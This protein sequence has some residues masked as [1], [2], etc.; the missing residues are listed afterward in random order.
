MW[1]RWW[2]FPVGYYVEKLATAIWS[3]ISTGSEQPELVEG[4]NYD[5]MH[6]SFIHE[7]LVE[8]AMY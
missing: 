6:E 8:Y 7:N 4:K 2:W 5:P 3:V 1:Q